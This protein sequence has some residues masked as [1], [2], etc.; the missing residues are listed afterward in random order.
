MKK[1]SSIRGD[2][3]LGL[4]CILAIG[5]ILYFVFASSFDTFTYVLLIGGIFSFLA[6][7]ISSYLMIKNKLYAG[8]SIACGIISLLVTAIHFNFRF[9]QN[10]VFHDVAIGLSVAILLFVS[11]IKLTSSFGSEN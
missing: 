10:K 6:F 2:I 8:F 7:S 3:I 1:K 9:N 5:V 4:F 11:I